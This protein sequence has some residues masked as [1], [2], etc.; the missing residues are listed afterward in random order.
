MK[1]DFKQMEAE[2]NLLANNMN[3]ITCFT[4]QISK[5]LQHS[6]NKISRLSS[7]HSLLTRL[8]FLLKLPNKLKKLIEEDCYVQ[9]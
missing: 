3:S 4:E 1:L 8:Q 9:V 5:T 6:R 2:M 7:I